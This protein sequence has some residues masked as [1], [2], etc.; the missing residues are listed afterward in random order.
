ME[1]WK[2]SIEELKELVELTNREIIF[3][4]YTYPATFMGRVRYHKRKVL[5]TESKKTTIKFNRSF[6]LKNNELFIKDTVEGVLSSDKITINRKGSYNAV[7]SSKY[8][9]INDILLN[10]LVPIESYKAEM[11]TTQI[12]RLFKL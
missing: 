3:Y 12:T 4:E 9:S 1:E 11:K 8:F 7:V 10:E 5:I 2:S 6:K